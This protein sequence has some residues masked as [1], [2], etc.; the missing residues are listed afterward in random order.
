MPLYLLQ[1]SV[2]R[3]P[4]ANSTEGVCQVIHVLLTQTNSQVQGGSV[5]STSP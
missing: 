3:L 5:S 1:L 4:H 2:G